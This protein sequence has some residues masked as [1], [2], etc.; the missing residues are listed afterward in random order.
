MKILALYLPQFYRTMENDKWW[1]EGFTEWTNVRKAEPIYRGHKQPV[2]PLNNNY[3]DLT[4]KNAILWQCQ[5]AKEYGVSGFVM[6]HY[7]YEGK[8]LLEKPGELLLKT[9]EAD[10]QYCFCWANHPWTRAWDGKEHQILQ[11]QTYG[12]KEDWE[13]HL[14]YYMPFFKDRRYIKKD[15]RPLLFIYNTGAI[16]QYQEMVE[17]WEQELIKQGF[18]GIR[19]AEFI[20]SKN[21]KAIG[22]KEDL[23]FEDEPI[24]SSRFEIPSCLKL[25][26]VVCKLLK[27][28]DYLDYNLLWKRI[29][30]KKHIYGD[31]EIIQGAFC[32]FD[33]SP[34]RGKKGSFIIKN[35]TPESFKKYFG[36]LLKNK[37]PNMCEDYIVMNAWNEWGEGAMLEPSKRYGYGYLEAIRENLCEG[38]D[39]IKNS[40]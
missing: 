3:Y 16:L 24:F 36:Q 2:L 34:R 31:R 26:R 35:S 14:N 22:R 15:N 5:T 8:L 9:G 13:K 6:Y 40:G 17:Y 25:K 39:E 28:P 10:I 23:I 33:N 32:S 1:G 19:I 18:D 7:W 38:N 20:N 27:L 11:A 30:H 21:T 12:G 37:R 29:L 4:D